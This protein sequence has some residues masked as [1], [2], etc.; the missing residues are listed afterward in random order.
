MYMIF[1]IMQE[2]VKRLGFLQGKEVEDNSFGKVKPCR[3]VDS[4]NMPF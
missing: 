1:G 3:L 2:V 4:S